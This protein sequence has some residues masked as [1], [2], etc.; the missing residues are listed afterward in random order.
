MIAQIVK[1]TLETLELSSIIF[2]QL[3][4]IYSPSRTKHFDKTICELGNITLTKAFGNQA[5]DEINYLNC[6]TK[7]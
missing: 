5:N 4:G 7:D 6:M 1:M 2:F 3:L